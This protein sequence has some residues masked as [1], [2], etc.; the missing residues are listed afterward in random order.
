MKEDTMTILDMAMQKE[1]EAEEFY[2]G[3]AEKSPNTGLTNILN[4]LA[5]VEAKHFE[6][7][8]RMQDEGDM[9]LDESG[10]AADFKELFD[11]MAAQ[12]QS[13]DFDISQVEMYRVAQEREAEARTFYEARAG[14]SDSEAAVTLF[15][16]LAAEET[17]HYQI[18]D[19][20]IEF[21]SRAEP[22]N[23]LEN[24]EWYHTES[25]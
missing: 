18:L 20:I 9:R 19:T 11:T 4:K 8:K 7:L 1:K 17:R 6:A 2:R 25:F 15:T 14:E 10:S 21:V 12:V 22:G 24:A 5:S 3:L 16:R 13:F 23:W